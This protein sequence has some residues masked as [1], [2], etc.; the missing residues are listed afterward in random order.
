VL[1]IE[2]WGMAYEVDVSG[3]EK[4]DFNESCYFDKNCTFN[5][6]ILIKYN[7]NQRI[8]E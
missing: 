1:K 2:I 4:L 6:L 5:Q 7:A 3:K 8:Y